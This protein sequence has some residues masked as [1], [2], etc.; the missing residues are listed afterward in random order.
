MGAD[1]DTMALGQR[2][3]LFHVVGVEELSETADRSDELTVAVADPLNDYVF[4]A[5][6]L[7]CDR[8]IKVCVGLSS[9][10]DNAIGKFQHNCR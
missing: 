6:S 5:L 10:I 4:N 1:L 9:D 7:A 2:H 8:S 3:G